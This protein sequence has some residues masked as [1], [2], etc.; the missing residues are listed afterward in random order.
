MSIILTCECGKRMKV[1]DNIAGRQGKCPWCGKVLT[2]PKSQPGDDGYELADLPDKSSA[3][4][5]SA[6]P[7][8]A[9][10]AAPT[11]RGCGQPMKPKAIICINCGYHSASGNY[12]KHHDEVDEAAEKPQ[13]KPIMELMGIRI[14]PLRLVGV[15]LPL[16]GLIFWYVNGP[17][18]DIHVL[19]AQVVN[20]IDSLD[21]GATREPYSLFTGEGDLSLGIKATQSNKNPVQGIAEVDEVFSL[22]KNDEVLIT[23]P[24]EHGAYVVIEVA[25]KQSAIRDKEQLSRYDSIIAAKH[26][27][28]EATDG[29][30][31]PVTGRLLYA[32]FDDKID[33]DM[34]GADTSNYNKLLPPLEPTYFDVQTNSGV[35]RG[36]AE[37]D[38]PNAQGQVNF[39]AFYSKGDLPPPKGLS[40]NGNL[41]ITNDD[42]AEVDFDYRGGTLVMTWSPD[43]T[44]WWGKTRYKKLTQMSPWY[45]YRFALIFERPA[46]RGKLQL[47]YCDVPIATISPSQASPA[48]PSDKSKYA[49]T[50]ASKSPLAYFSIAAQTKKRAQ[51]IVSA[52]N[53]QNIGIAISMYLDQNG[54]Q[55]PDQLE[56]LEQY[57]GN[58]EQL[59]INPRTS[60]NP[61]FLYQKPAAGADPESTPV[62]YE[63]DNGKKDPDGAI[64]YADGH[65]EP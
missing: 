61:G 32:R 1:A 4:G 26:F 36:E 9:N 19:S 34:G 50:K 30:S 12:V 64:L 23:Q 45:R 22:G 47:S 40:A 59:L 7:P 42:G 21:G 55:W 56:Q 43:A 27:K 60:A 24:S 29:G 41:T 17:R 44:G 53:M 39:T 11:C 48:E 15:M 5:A 2:I 35:I 33:I 31:G 13:R 54:G 46:G 20:V 63:I 16:I 6:P 52:S 3:P 62:I 49:A 14:T 51:G 37:W 25:L 8:T 38:E 28:L 65:V 18:R 58:M 10:A 57:L